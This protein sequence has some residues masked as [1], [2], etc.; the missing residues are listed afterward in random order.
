MANLN[1]PPSRVTPNLLHILNAFTDSSNSTIVL[2]IEFELLVKAFSIC[3]KFG[4][5]LLGG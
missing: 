5:T 1:Q 2:T 3:N 4:V